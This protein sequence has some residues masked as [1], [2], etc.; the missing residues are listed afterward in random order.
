MSYNMLNSMWFKGI[1]D[2][3]GHSNSGFLCSFLDSA[4]LF[5]FVSKLN[6]LYISGH[7]FW[8]AF[9][10]NEGNENIKVHFL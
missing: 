8:E 5:G 4:L 1:L 7:Q 3:K 10:R 6:L 9:I 2:I